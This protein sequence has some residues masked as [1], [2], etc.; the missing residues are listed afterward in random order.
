MIETSS[1]PSQGL[2]QQI[3]DRARPRGRALF[4]AAMVFAFGVF[5]YMEASTYAQGSLLRMGP[6]YF[7][8]VLAWLLM[9]LGVGLVAEALWNDPEEPIQPQFRSTAAIFASVA[10]F[11]FCLER[12]GLLP[13]VFLSVMVSSL[14][15]NRMTVLQGFLT[16]SVLAAA[17]AAIFVWMLGLPLAILTW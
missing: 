15:D 4:G 1:S 16:A 12:Y 7:P 14:A 17:S 13:S 10:I 11:A 3:C 6:G 5:I 9:A 8:V 2:V